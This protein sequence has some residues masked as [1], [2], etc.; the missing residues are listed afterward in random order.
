MIITNNHT[1][2]QVVG[3]IHIR[4][5]DSVDVSGLDEAKFRACPAFTAGA[6]S[7]GPPTPRQKVAQ[8][9]PEQSPKSIEN[10][11]DPD[12]VALIQRT[13]DLDTLRGWAA[14]TRS[15]GVMTAIGTQIR[16]AA[17]K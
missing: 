4:P 2:V 6:L 11:S 15:P 8:A 16:I 10:L 7:I 1:A 12:A 17:S 13:L 5:G 3:D 14:L 9:L